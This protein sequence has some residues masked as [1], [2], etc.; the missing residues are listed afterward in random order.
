M[1]YLNW[2]GYLA[3]PVAF[4]LHYFIGK[5]QNWEP[6]AT[7]IAAALGVIPLAHLMGE[8]T[9]HL[10]ERTGP[11]WGGLLNAT[12]GNAAELIIAIIALSKGLNEIVKAS[13]TGSIIGNLLLV[14]GAAM[15]AGGWKREQQTF[16]PKAAE[17]NSGLLALSV[18][19]LIVPAIF[20]FTAEARH[21]V[22][23]HEHEHSV[24]MGTSFVLLIVYGLGLLF[25]LRTHKHILSPQP[26]QSEEDR[27]GIS[28]LHPAWSVGRSI[29]M[30]LLASA[31]VAIV[32]ELLVGSAEHMAQSLGWNHVFV[33]VI[34][35]AIIGNAAEHST[36]LLLAMR[37]DMD[38]AMT[39]T[40][41]SSI[42]IALFVTPLL[43]LLSAVMVAMGA[44]N[45]H[46]LDLVFSPMEVVAVMVSVLIVI[47]LAINGES[48]W[49]EG[50]LLLALYAILG[51]AFFY[52]PTGSPHE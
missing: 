26:A 34:L 17:T 48:N 22:A 5:G 38:T 46:H 13:L 29:L 27:P 39:I 33:G 45:A 15:V 25:T 28:A 43:V 32:A 3:I 19:M 18:A 50:A 7:F 52:I 10:S 6:A 47:V 31:G 20:H 44:H 49:L 37:D 9:E 23:I 24:S 8:A 11:T 21:D 4:L 42:Q 1:R 36:A 12:F 51:I 30:L 35:L 14:G 41:Q 2:I 16:N 40:F